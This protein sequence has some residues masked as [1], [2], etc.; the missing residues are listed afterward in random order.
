MSEDTSHSNDLSRRDFLATTGDAAIA[1]GTGALGA[2]SLTGSAYA[3]SPSARTDEGKPLNIL[4]IL[5]DQERYLDPRTLPVG[6]SLPGRER[7][8]KEGATTR[9][10]MP[11]TCSA[12]GAPPT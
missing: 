11:A 12:P 1:A 2:S 4:F 10:S 3:K 6:Y 5:T 9:K 7:I 8:R